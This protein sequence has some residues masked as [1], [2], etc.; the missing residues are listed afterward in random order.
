MS[1]FAINAHQFNIKCCTDIL[2]ERE[3]TQA[4]VSTMRQLTHTVFYTCAS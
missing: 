4:C 2:V 3:L 1:M